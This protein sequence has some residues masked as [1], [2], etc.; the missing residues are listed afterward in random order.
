MV[1]NR[2][3]EQYNPLKLYFSANW[4]LSRLK[5]AEDS[6]YTYLFEISTMGL[7]EICKSK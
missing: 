6:F 7:A 2:I 5:S 4:Q 3:V 1:V